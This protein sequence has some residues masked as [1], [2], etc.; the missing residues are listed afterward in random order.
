LPGTHRSHDHLNENKQVPVSESI[1]AHW[2]RE[3][4]RISKE[5]REKYG[6]RLVW[7][8]VD[9]FLMYWNKACFRFIALFPVRAELLHLTVHQKA[10]DQFDIR[11]FLR[12]P[13]D[14][15]KQRRHER[16]G[17]HTAGNS[18]LDDSGGYLTIQVQ[19]DPEG[20]LWRDPPQY[21]EQIVYPAY[22]RAHSDLFE[23][24]DVEHGKPTD[25]VPELLLFDGSQI[26]M[27]SMLTVVM[28]KVIE[29]T[30]A[31]R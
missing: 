3:S 18:Y 23:G 27:G 21:W 1:T 6:V 19:S 24:G 8:I 16:H 28:E 9:G 31:S 29:F 12:V 4:E 10:I 14:V 15:L 20:N 26:N 5:H 7:A 17:Y 30:A 22:F 11:V 13:H 2:R 25:K